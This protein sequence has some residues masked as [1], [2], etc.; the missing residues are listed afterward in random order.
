MPSFGLKF[1]GTQTLA[2]LEQAEGET[3]NVFGASFALLDQRVFGIEG[4][5]AFL[6]GYFERNDAVP[7]WSGSSVVGLSANLI[8]AVPLGVTREGLRPYLVSGFGLLHAAAD[9]PTNTF[10]I[11]ST[12]PALTFGGGAMGMLSRNTGVRF[13]LRYQ[14]SLGQE[15]GAVDAEGPRLALWRASVAYVRRF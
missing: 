15:G 4:D 13:D 2:D 8:V 3:K 12:M 5:F 10:N 11:S 1:S 9:E 7:I 14:R 6:P